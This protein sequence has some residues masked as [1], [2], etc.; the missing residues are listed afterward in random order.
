MGLDKF[1]VTL[2]FWF[3]EEFSTP[4]RVSM[5]LPYSGGTEILATAKVTEE[6]TTLSSQVCIHMYFT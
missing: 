4:C 5:T 6:L 2:G 1:F 3:Q